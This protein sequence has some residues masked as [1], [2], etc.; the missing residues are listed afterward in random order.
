MTARR[1]PA[2]DGEPSAQDLEGR[3]RDDG[4]SPR[5]WGNQPGDIYARHSHEYHKVLYCARGSIT[6]HTDEGDISLEAGDRLDIDPGTEHGA[7]VGPRGVRCVEAPR[8]P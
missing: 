3:L 5:W 6:F 8:G 7:T 4:L 1:T 2:T